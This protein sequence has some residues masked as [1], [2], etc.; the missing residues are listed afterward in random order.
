WRLFD[1]RL[2]LCAVAGS[3]ARARDRDHPIQK[4]GGLD[5]AHAR[6][7]ELECLARGR[8]CTVSLLETLEH[9]QRFLDVPGRLQLR[10]EHVTYL[11]SLVDHAGVARTTP[12]I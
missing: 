4:R 10:I 6:P 12:S 3:G 7:P 11:A 5:A 1:R 9:L 8:H 2:R